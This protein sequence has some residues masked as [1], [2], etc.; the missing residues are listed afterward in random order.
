MMRP[1]SA[2]LVL[3][4]ASAVLAQVPLTSVYSTPDVPS[5][6]VLRRLNLKKGWARYV[7][8]AG[9]RDGFL[10]IQV[11]GKDLLAQTRSG[12][13]VRM[14]AETGRIYWRQRVGRPYKGGHGVAF[15]SRSVYAINATDL[16]SLSRT[17]GEQRWRYKLPG[18]TSALP[19]ADDRHLYLSTAA[20]RIY[21]YYLPSTDVPGPSTSDEGDERETDPQPAVRWSVLT[22][23]SLELPPLVT[24]TRVL[25][26]SPSGEIRL[27]EKVVTD[28]DGGS[29]EESLALRGKID[30]PAGQF[31]DVAYVG[32][33]DGS[34]YALEIETGKLAWRYTAGTPVKRQP[35]PTSEDV[36]VTM[37]RYGLVRVSRIDVLDPVSR[38]TLEAGQKVWRNRDAD[39]F[40]AANPKFVY[41]SDH[42]GRLLVLDRKRGTKLSTLD[43][44][45]FRF[46][47][48]NTMTD[49]IYLAANDGLIVC[50]HDRDYPRPFNHR[51]LE[52][53]ADPLKKKLSTL[54]THKG[55]KAIALREMIKDLEKA[56]N[57]KI[58]V[59]E[60][61]FKARRIDNVMA[62]EV[63]HPAV[64]NRPLE[65]VLAL[66][67]KQAGAIF[68][69]FDDSI[70]VVPAPIRDKE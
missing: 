30:V 6:E 10:T 62:V 9:R 61:A 41:A 64:V 45:Q 55:G 53:Q 8:M 28:T 2:G 23:V 31:G 7:P 44:R 52:E 14:D 48:A 24:R 57:L 18:G 22:T 12:L 27:F 29:R 47:I 37:D 70:I 51:I 68:E 33:S 34:L 65:A 56:H 43:A 26:P 20:G 60:A 21:S 13:I 39:R 67:F 50:L 58:R 16:F 42:S 54:V 35:M 69:V 11:A 36:Y 46:P 3:L 1:L 5:E 4:L 15:N 40:V 19:I 49:R 66:V 59:V 38:R 32:S 17:T 25:V 63:K